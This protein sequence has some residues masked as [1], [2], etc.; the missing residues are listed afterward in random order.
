MRNGHLH[1]FEKFTRR[2]NQAV[3]TEIPDLIRLIGIGQKRTESLSIPCGSMV[4]Y[5]GLSLCTS[6]SVACS[7]RP[8]RGIPLN[9][10]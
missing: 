1:D 6:A 3:V 9:I 8:R 4:Y 7:L 5:G 2:M 10:S